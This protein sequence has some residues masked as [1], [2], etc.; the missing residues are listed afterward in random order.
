MPAPQHDPTGHT[1]HHSD[2]QLF[3]MTKFGS[4]ALVPGYE[5]DMPGFKDKLSDADIWVVIS[6]IERTWPQAIRDKEQRMNVNR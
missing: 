6:Y 3:D 4:G 1:W 2:K 5:G